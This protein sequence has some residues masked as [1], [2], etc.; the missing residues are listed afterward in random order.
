[1]GLRFGR[2]YFRLRE[3]G[4]F[5]LVNKAM[6]QGAKVRL[7]QVAGFV[8]EPDLEERPAELPDE[9]AVL[10]DEEPGLRAYYDA[11]SEYARREIGKWVRDVKSDAARVRRAEQMAERLLATMEAEKE[12]PP[13]LA[14]AFKQRPKAKTGWAK[15]TPTQRRMELFACFYYKTPEALEKR[16]TK[17]CDV[18]EKKAI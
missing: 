4:Y 17:L 1:M 5:L 15:M 12:L 18:A 9:L 8:L 7:G 11:M 13:V 3:R 2:R 10:L 6:Q 16:V 14:R